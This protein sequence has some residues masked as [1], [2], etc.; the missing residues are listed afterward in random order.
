MCP[1]IDCSTMDDGNYP[2][3]P[4]ACQSNFVHCFEG[5][6][7][8]LECSSGKVFSIDPSY[9]YCEDPQYCGQTTLTTTTQPHCKTHFIL[10]E[11][12]FS[13]FQY[14]SFVFYC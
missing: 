13:V 12:P 14:S 2:C 5:T 8:V 4:N 11:C 1:S 9:P 6:K 10:S 7:S 3:T